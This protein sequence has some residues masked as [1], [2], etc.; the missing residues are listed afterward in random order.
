LTD[1]HLLGYKNFEGRIPEGEYGAGAVIVWDR[2]KYRN[3]KTEMSMQS[4]FRK[5]HIEVFLKGKKLYGAFALVRFREKNWLLIKMK[6]D[7]VNLRKNVVKSEP[8][9]VKSGKTIHEV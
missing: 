2:G 8:H 1:D 9:S 6:D 7:Y 4:C 3:L 5:G